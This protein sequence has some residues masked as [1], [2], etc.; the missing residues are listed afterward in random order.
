[1]IRIAYVLGAVLTLCVPRLIQ[2]S[3]PALAVTKQTLDNG[4]E[5]ILHENHRLPFVTVEVLYRA[6]SGSEP[7]GKSGLAHLLEHMAN[8]GGSAHIRLG[9]NVELIQSMG[10]SVEAATGLDATYYYSFAP[11]NHLETLLWIQ[12]E[13]MGFLEPALTDALLARDK[14][15]VKNER[16]QRVEGTPYGPAYGVASLKALQLLFPAPHPYFG[17]VLGSDEEID[18]I[19]LE[20][21]KTFYR[22]YYC[23]SNASL[24]IDGDFEASQVKELVAKYF[25][26]SPAC[27][28]HRETATSLQAPPERE[29]RDTVFAAV[30]APQVSFAWLTGP[31]FSTGDPELDLLSI[32]LG[33]GQGGILHKRLVS[34]LQIAS[35]ASCQYRA[36]LYGSIFK[37]DIVMAPSTSEDQIAREMDA[38]IEN[39]RNRGPST[40]ELARAKARWKAR[41]FGRME[42][43]FVRAY[44]INYQYRRLAGDAAHFEPDLSQH[45][46]VTP[47]LVRDI[48][49]RFLD[50]SKRAVVMMR[51]TG[52]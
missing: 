34:S 19:T 3:T 22:S 44:L 27:R 49:G 14:A 5:V 51:P 35:E 36:G 26:G 9:G 12:S 31:A 48:A 46:A 52:K 37:C 28:D 47:N 4:L 10:G 17:N 6:G 41:I 29:R 16:R 13:R 32:V 24:L 15:S 23:P 39:V 43:T 30:K 7:P 11:A 45:E 8:S 50:P 25:R 21:V 38:I 33:D 40:A 42:S 1:M 20:D 18:S 2:A